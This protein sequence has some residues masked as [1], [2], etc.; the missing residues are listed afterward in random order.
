[1]SNKSTIR[2]TISG[3]INMLLFAFVPVIIGVSTLTFYQKLFYSHL[4]SLIFL[5]LLIAFLDFRKF[6]S[7][8]KTFNSIQLS[9]LF[10]LGIL[11]VFMSLC[12][13]YA[14][15]NGPRIE[16]NIITLTWPIFLVL[17]NILLGNQKIGKIE[18]IG[19]FLGFT[20]SLFI[21]LKGD[22][23][24]NILLSHYTYKYSVLYAILGGIYYFIY[25]K[26]KESIF[27]T[28]EECI[29]RET[30]ISHLF[31][32]FWQGF[33]GFILIVAIMPLFPDT[34]NIP[35][36]EIKWALLLGIVGYA[37]PQFFIS[38][39]NLNMKPSD[40]A[41]LRYLNPVICTAYLSIILD[42]KIYATTIIGS[43]LIFSCIH[44]IITKKSCP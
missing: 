27:S 14:L 12:F 40:F 41:T 1:M 43:V 33:L 18:A 29:N 8:S 35:T 37:L 28:N 5:F 36:Q 23:F 19:L 34:L 9:K 16:N 24:E 10:G 2:G 6:I 7:F 25:K 21:T 44:L 17:F 22:S 4:V 11:R 20:G 42:D 26:I 39:S 31:M 3:V 15:S 32:I 38:Y 13:F 30:V